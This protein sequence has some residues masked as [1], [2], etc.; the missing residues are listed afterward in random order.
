MSRKKLERKSITKTVRNIS[1]SLAN[2]Q[3]GVVV[4]RK[5][6]SYDKS[7]ALYRTHLLEK[8]DRNDRNLWKN[9]SESVIDLH[10]I[11]YQPP[12]CHSR[13]PPKVP[14]KQV[15]E[16]KK[17]KRKKKKDYDSDDKKLTASM[18]N[19][20]L[21]ANKLPI[22]KTITTKPNKR[23]F[24][25]ARYVRQ[26]LVA[27]SE[28]VFAEVGPG[29][30][31]R[32]YQDTFTEL[33]LSKGCDVASEHSLTLKRTGSKD[34][35]RRADLIISKQGV[36]G[37]VLLELKA[38]KKFEKKDF[39][40]ILN[41]QDHFNINECYLIKFWD[42]AKVLRWQSEANTNNKNDCSMPPL[43]V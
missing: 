7:L 32:K 34:I 13:E 38:K 8:T 33:L 27:W 20:S 16:K 28:Q 26:N 25:F 40:Q 10:G 22:E 36:T 23:N 6:E 43:A 29:Q 21:G 14:A 35:I 5:P 3:Q 17:E 42:G 18:K 37:R 31:E 30:K 39:E 11:D 4:A 24:N 12:A 2:Q 1:S 19:L 9:G 15:R 41:Y